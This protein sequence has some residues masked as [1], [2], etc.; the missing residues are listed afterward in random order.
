M[1]QIAF[2]F[3]GVALADDSVVKPKPSKPMTLPERPATTMADIRDRTAADADIADVRRRD[4]LSGLNRFERISGRS[5]ADTPATASA[6]RTVFEN[7][8][9]ARLGIARKSLQTLRSSVAFALRRFGPIE[10]KSGSPIKQNWN[11]EW[12]ALIGRIQISFQR[13]A[14]SRLAEF[15]SRH[16]IAPHAVSQETLADFLAALTESEAVKIPKHVVHNT[17][18]S[19]NRAAREIP[20]WPPILLSSPTKPVPHILPMADFPAGFQADLA[21]WERRTASR[22]KSV[23]IFRGEG[24]LRRLRPETVKSQLSLFRQVASAL[25]KSG[26]MKLEEIDSLASLCEPDKLR[27][28]LE[29]EHERLGGNDRRVLEMANKMRVLSKHFG[30]ITPEQVAG[31]D[32]LCTDRPER[33]KEITEQNRLRL[34]QFD[35]PGNYEKLVSFP[36]RAV[37]Q[38]RR[39]KNRYRAAKRMEQAVAVSILLRVAPRLATLRQ[40]ELSWLIHQTDG[41]IILSVPRTALKARRALELQLNADCGAL[42]NELIRDFRPALPSASGPYLFPGEKGGAR[43]KNAMYEQITDVGRELGLDINPHLYRH[44]L[45]KVCAERDRHSVG[46]VS[47]VLGHATTSTTVAFYA[48]RSGRAASKRLDALLSAGRDTKDEVEK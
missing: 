43:S 14:L 6:I 16:L 45:Q 2:D 47:R 26:A 34:A 3:S 36:A 23:S 27:A 22:P 18:S 1:E 10:R 9:S 11:A 39:M 37:A 20:G 41:S 17:I 29:F 8:N 48:D 33:L 28:A 5:L 42:I 44:L 7:A 19:W 25:V 31:L 21:A 40:I 35:K 32:R 24:P 4:L 38:A 15:C 46:D 13:H 12:A 30:N